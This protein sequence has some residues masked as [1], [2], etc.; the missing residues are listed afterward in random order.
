MLLLCFCYDASSAP[1]HIAEYNVLLQK[2]SSRSVSPL[3]AV[4]EPA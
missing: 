2:S 4:I 3:V 1:H